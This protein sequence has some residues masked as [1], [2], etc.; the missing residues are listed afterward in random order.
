MF[1]SL[2]YT[3][4]TDFHSVQ[5]ERCF[6]IFISTLLFPAISTAVYLRAKFANGWTTWKTL[7]SFIM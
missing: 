1:S 6:L 4:E 5:A 2:F 7:F 3:K